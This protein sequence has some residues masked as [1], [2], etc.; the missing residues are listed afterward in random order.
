VK[1]YHGAI[2]GESPNDSIPSFGNAA[3]YDTTKSPLARPGATATIFGQSG[4]IDAGAGI[5]TDLSAGNLAGVVGAIQKGGTAF[6]TFKGRDLTEMFK[7]ESTNMAR[8]VIKEDLPGAARGSGFF[9]KQARF[10]NINEQAATLK[11]A[12]TGTTTN[13]TNINGPITVPNQVGTN[14]NRRG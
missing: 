2:N 9:P 1:Y 10:T 8:S 12:N 3:N 11:S 13:P 6:E 4:L 5:I 7:T 14:P